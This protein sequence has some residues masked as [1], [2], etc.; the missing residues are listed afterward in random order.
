[1]FTVYSQQ[2]QSLCTDIHTL[3]EQSIKLL[4]LYIDTVPPTIDKTLSQHEP[5]LAEYTSPAS[6]KMV[7]NS[8]YQPVAASQCFHPAPAQLLSW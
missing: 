1:M 4:T 6:M 5:V 8:F 3:V 2:D 7:H